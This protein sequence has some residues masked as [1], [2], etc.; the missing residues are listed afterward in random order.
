[1]KLHMTDRTRGPHVDARRDVTVRV[2]DLAASSCF[3]VNC[4]SPT[5]VCLNT[6]FSIAGL[7]KFEVYMLLFL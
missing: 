6:I 7:R 2:A 1:M 4:A 5:H 3:L